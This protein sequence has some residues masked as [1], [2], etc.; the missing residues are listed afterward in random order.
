[1]G[2]GRAVAPVGTAAEAYDPSPCSHA[3]GALD[4]AWS[5]FRKNILAPELKRV[6]IEVFHE[7]RFALTDE[8]VEVSVEARRHALFGPY[9]DYR[10]RRTSTRIVR[11]GIV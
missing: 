5:M 1:M 6:G 10:R 3:S 7:S 2:P 11:L 8:E 9:R 4:P